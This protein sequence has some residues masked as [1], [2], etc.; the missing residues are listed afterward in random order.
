MIKFLKVIQALLVILYILVNI[1][2]MVFNWDVYTVSMD[3]NYG[4]GSFSAPLFLVVETIGL[5]L[6]FL[7]WLTVYSKDLRY[8][9]SKLKREKD[10]HTKKSD[11]LADTSE[12]SGMSLNERVSQLQKQ[13]DDLAN[14]LKKS[15]TQDI[16][17]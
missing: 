10:I 15:E 12:G 17:H 9:I 16:D 5:I 8:E 13:M 11:T 3:L 2:L 14:L 6:I 7:L 1:Y 4:F